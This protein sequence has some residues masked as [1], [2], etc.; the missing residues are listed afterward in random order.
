ML[1]VR[2]S[3]PLPAGAD[4]CL[5]CF[6]LNPGNRE[7]GQLPLPLELEASQ[8]AGTPPAPS[9]DESG[10]SIASDPPPPLTASFDSDPPPARA[11]EPPAAETILSAQ[12]AGFELSPPEE[13]DAPGDPSLLFEVSPLRLPP[14]RYEVWQSFVFGFS[15]KDM[16]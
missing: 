1:C 2:C 15:T 14:D 5:R 12:E 9:D 11:S 7:R 10:L 6:S 4:R 3:H 8:T 13:S 16:Q